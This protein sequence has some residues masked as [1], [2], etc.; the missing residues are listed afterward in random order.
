MSWTDA[1]IKKKDDDG[2]K[3]EESQ[4][5]LTPIKEVAQ[6]NY[7]PLNNRPS[8][9]NSY[10]NNVGVDQKA[11][12]K[13]QDIFDKSNMPGADL[14]EFITS[15][16]KL[17]GKNLDEKTKYEMIFDAQ[18]A[19]GLTKDKL[20]ESGTFYVNTFNDVKN[21]FDKE[22]Q[23]EVLEG[24]T[25]LNTQADNVIQ[26]NANYQKQIEEIN[27]KIS[28]NLTRMQSLR[29]EAST[30]ENKLMQE[31]MSFENSYNVFISSLQKHITNVNTYIQ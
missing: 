20:I 9:I 31:K 6:T 3:K 4:E 8:P 19:V 15:I 13:L 30:N 26:E 2:K 16:K 5:S 14:Y 28:D 24:V 10:Q 27:K 25:K 22:Y 1:F 7:N 23:N 29:T 21:E 12:D 17:E 11:L 18:S